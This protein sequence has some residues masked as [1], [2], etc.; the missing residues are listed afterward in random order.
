MTETWIL[1]AL[2]LAFAATHIGLSS[3]RFRPRLHAALGER[4]FLGVYSL[5]A[6]A[7]F[8]PI[9]WYY[10]AHKHAGPLLWA[11][12]IGTGLRWVLYAGMGLAFV[13]MACAFVQPSPQAL[14]GDRSAPLTATQRITRHSLFMGLALFA[15][16]HL[17]PNGYASDVAF[18]GGMAAFSVVGSWHQDRRKLVLEAET[19]GPFAEQTPFIPFTGSETLAGLR[20]LPWV[21]LGAG[22]VLTVVLRYFHASLF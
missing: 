4:G 14:G 10:F 22:V 15:L 7:T 18:F 12:P 17:I 16:I 11:L 19:Y 6:L 5:I 9:V 8:V 13:L 2:W 20:G 21:G 1:I 3:V